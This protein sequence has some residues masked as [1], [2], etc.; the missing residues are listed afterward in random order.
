[1]NTV[2]FE[3]LSIGQSAT[4]TKTITAK[5]LELFGEVTGDLNPVHFDETY[6]ATTQF[7]KRI[8]HGM[9]TGSLFSTLLGTQLPGAGSIYVGQTL[10]FKRPVFLN[11]TLTVS[12]EVS[13][14]ED[15]KRLVTLNCSI[16]NQDNK[17]VVTGEAQAIAPSK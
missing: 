12:I 8:A 11:D 16:K 15:K 2:Y 10:S 1:M 3:D 13:T 6:A 4:L 7:K 14:L 17:V 9:L 5:D